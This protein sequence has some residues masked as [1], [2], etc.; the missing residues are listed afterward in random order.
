MVI[1]NKVNFCF[2]LDTLPRPLY[3][4]LRGKSLN[5]LTSH[6]KEAELLLSQAVKQNPGL[7][8]AWN[9]LGES[10]WK[11]GNVIQA[12]HCFIGALRHVN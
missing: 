5:V 8:D 10:Y 1:I 12:H 3:Q 9:A 6:S 7:V 4:Y 2:T 11:I